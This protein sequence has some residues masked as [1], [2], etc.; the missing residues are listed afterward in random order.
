VRA[1]EGLKLA[2][3]AVGDEETPGAGELERLLQS[4]YRYALSLTHDRPAAEDLIQDA[5][6][7]VV[8]CG[9]KW[10]KP[11]LFTA[12]RNRFIDKYRRDRRLVLLPLDGGS[13][14]GIDPADQG[15]W[16]LPDVIEH[17][18]LHRALGMLRVAEREMVF[19][20][21][22]EG[23]TTQQIAELTRRPRGTVL[24]SLHRTKLKLRRLLQRGSKE[25]TNE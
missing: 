9:G 21:F 20:A 7:S 14:G 10:Q 6:A 12:I 18:A 1:G 8:R 3:F 4:G 11:Y 5:A 23:Y 2:P 19:L 22:V 24:S 13:E 16:E 15:S 25:G 17:R